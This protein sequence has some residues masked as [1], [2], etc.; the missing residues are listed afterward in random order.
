M[1][2]FLILCYVYWFKVQF[3]GGQSCFPHFQLPEGHPAAASGHSTLTSPCLKN[4]S[5]CPP[6]SLLLLPCF[7]AFH[8][9]NSL[10]FPNKA[11]FFLVM[12]VETI[13][14]DTLK[15]YKN[16]E[17]ENHLLTHHLDVTVLASVL[18]GSHSHGWPSSVS[19]IIPHEWVYPLLPPPPLIS[20]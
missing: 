3:A 17:R 9:Q 19:G 10:F 6:F 16:K 11:F 20:P 5:L 14:W 8:D 1:Q 4:R 13:H 2:L 15:W 7:D 18:L 12:K